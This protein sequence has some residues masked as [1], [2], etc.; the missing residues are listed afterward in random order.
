MA[1][2][3]SFQERKIGYKN[4]ANLEKGLLTKMYT[5][6][7]LLSVLLGCPEDFMMFLVLFRLL[8]TQLIRL[9]DNNFSYLI[10]T[11]SLSIS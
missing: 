11:K 7:K 6:I 3:N 2:Y 9:T 8:E 5:N 4:L 10:L 1:S